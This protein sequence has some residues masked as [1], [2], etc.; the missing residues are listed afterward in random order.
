[1]I[2]ELVR[3][4]DAGTEGLVTRQWQNAGGLMHHSRYALLQTNEGVTA[5]DQ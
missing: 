2:H 4:V 1:M 3:I 5:N